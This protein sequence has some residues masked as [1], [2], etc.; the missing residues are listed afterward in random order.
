MCFLAVS[1]SETTL[2][3][4][5]QFVQPVTGPFGNARLDKDKLHDPAQPTDAMGWAWKIHFRFEFFGVVGVGYCH[6]FFAGTVG[7]LRSPR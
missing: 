2:V 6:A 5:D 4:R 7:Q 1:L 3:G